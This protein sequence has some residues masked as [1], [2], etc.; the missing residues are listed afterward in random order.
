MLSLFKILKCSHGDTIQ[1]YI[2]DL[3]DTISHG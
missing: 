2:E 3:G 1:R